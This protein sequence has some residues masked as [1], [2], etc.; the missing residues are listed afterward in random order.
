MCAMLYDVYCMCVVG[1]VPCIYVYVCMLYFV[2]YMIY[3]MCYVLCYGLCYVLY[4]M[5][6]TIYTIR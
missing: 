3:D 5:Y 4:D 6:Y 1:A 2:C